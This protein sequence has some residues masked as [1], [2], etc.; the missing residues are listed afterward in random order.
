MTSS[1]L[2]ELALPQDFIPL[3]MTIQSQDDLLACRKKSMWYEE[4]AMEVNLFAGGFSATISTNGWLQFKLHENF[5][6]ENPHLKDDFEDEDL[7]SGPTIQ[8]I[9]SEIGAEEE[10]EGDLDFITKPIGEIEEYN[11]YELFLYQNL[12]N[13]DYRRYEADEE[14]SYANT[15][16]D[17]WSVIGYAVEQ[18]ELLCTGGFEGSLADE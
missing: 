16:D 4:N 12:I 11:I 10:I 8:E 6:S 5:L 14:L 15:L 13:N 17:I 9:M 1:I 18:L 3:Y 2:S 7:F